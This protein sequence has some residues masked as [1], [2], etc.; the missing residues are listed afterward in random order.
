MGGCLHGGRGGGQFVG[1]AV[2]VVVQAVGPLERPV[3]GGLGRAERVAAGDAVVLLAADAD[4]VA[5]AV[6]VG[7]EAGLHVCIAVRRAAGRAAA[8]VV[9]AAGLVREATADLGRLE[10]NAD[11]ALEVRREVRR[12]PDDQVPVLDP[13]VFDRRRADLEADEMPHCKTSLQ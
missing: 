8:G 6:G 7:L 1:R 4:A 5:V 13:S 12:E 9:V 2:A 10:P 11:P 3:A